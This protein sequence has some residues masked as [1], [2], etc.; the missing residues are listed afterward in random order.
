MKLLNTGHNLNKKPGTIAVKIGFFTASIIMI[1]AIS[2]CSGGS[3]KG[4]DFDVSLCK[5]GKITVWGESP[6]FTSKAASRDKAKEDACRIAVQKCIGEEISAISNVS[7]GQSIGNEI[8]AQAKGICRN[9]Q[10]VEEKEYMLDTV[11]MLRVFVRFQVDP[12]ALQNRIDTMQK[13]VGNPKVIIL[14]REEYNLPR[15]GKRVE[16]FTSRNGMVSASLREYLVSKGYT[17][18]DPKDAAR[19]LNEAQVAGN[20]DNI[21]DKI[22]DKAMKAG[23]DV[24]IVGKIEANPQK[25]EV[26]AFK[27]SG[28]KSFKATGNLSILSLWGAGRVLGEYN[29]HNNGAQTTDLAAAQAAMKR[30]ALGSDKSKP[31]GAASFIHRKLSTEWAEQ[32]RNNVIQMKIRGLPVKDAGTFRD[33]LQERTNVRQINEISSSTNE[34]VWEVVYPGRSFALADSIAFYGNNP[35]MFFVVRDTGKNIN[36]TEVKRG[37]IRVQFK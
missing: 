26:E 2:F 25:I 31:A 12:A 15:G 29:Q 7:D 33:D 14:I 28:L 5:S 3:K 9:D 22:K 1:Y 24:L 11:K 21:P 27:R 4:G 18:V 30:Y 13:L 32:T 20:A 34:V 37:L 8:F 16:G 10:I 36:V 35:K 19:G 6:V 23:A 17:V